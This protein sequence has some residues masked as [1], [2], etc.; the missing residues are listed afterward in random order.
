MWYKHLVECSV[1]IDTTIIS[2][3]MCLAFDMS[4]K[5][6]GRDEHM[7]FSISISVGVERYVSPL[8]SYR[9]MIPSSQL[10]FDKKKNQCNP[11]SLGWVL[12]SRRNL[13][14]TG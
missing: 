12:M 7:I 6:L 14:D 3:G 5:D 10:K 8:L 4:Y 13:P 9:L 11:P 1:R 2:I